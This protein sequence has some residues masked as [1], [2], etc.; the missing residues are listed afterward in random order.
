M[1]LQTNEITDTHSIIGTNIEV[2][3]LTAK[4]GAWDALTHDKDCTPSILVS[5]GCTCFLVRRALNGEVKFTVAFP[6]S[7]KLITYRSVSGRQLA[8]GRE[9]GNGDLR[10]LSSFESTNP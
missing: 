5:D 7:G 8:W 9:G 3:I 6:L 10:R 2:E 4:L 1:D